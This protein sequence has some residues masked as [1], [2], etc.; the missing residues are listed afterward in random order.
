[1]APRLS[2]THVVL[3]A[4]AP[5]LVLLGFTQP[6]LPVEAILLL[7]LALL[8]G[9]T[10]TSSVLFPSSVLLASQPPILFQSSFQI[11]IHC[12]SLSLFGLFE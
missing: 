3:L 8:I 11:S 10:V 9:L 4:L 1:M 12:A 2:P 7:S 5:T 6:L